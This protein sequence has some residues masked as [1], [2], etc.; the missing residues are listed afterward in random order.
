MRAD[1]S[2][3][4]VL[5]V[6]DSKTQSMMLVLAFEDLGYVC[7]TA[8]TLKEAHQKL[9]EKSYDLVTLDINLPDGKGTDLLDKFDVFTDNKTQVAI[10]SG[11]AYSLPMEYLRSYNILDYF[12]KDGTLAKTV[13]DIDK[14]YRNR[15]NNSE[16]KIVVVDDSEEVRSTLH[17]L[18]K[19][20]NYQVFEA[21][22][23]EE[24]L[25][26]LEEQ[27][28][29]MLLLDLT[30]S[31][32]PGSQ[33]LEKVK[34]KRE[35]L[36][37]PVLILSEK[38]PS[39]VISKMYKLG[40]SDFVRK[41]FVYEELLIKVDFWVD[42]YR[43]HV[44]LLSEQKFLKEY[45]NAVDASNIVSKADKYG[46]ITFVNDAFC[47]VSGYT[48]EELVGQ[49]HKIVRHPD[50]KAEVFKD[51]WQTIAA[52]KL[53]RGIIKNRT[54][55]GRHY[56]VDTT[57]SPIT[58][59]EGNIVE[60]IAVRKDITELEEIRQT[61]KEELQATTADFKEVLEEKQALMVQ[62]A[63]FR[64]MEEMIGNIAHQWRQPLAALGLVIQK[65]KL[66]YQRGKLDE[67]KIDSIIEKSM[68]L[69]NEMSGTIDDFRN[70]F[71]PNKEKEYFDVGEMIA[72]AYAVVRRSFAEYQIEYRSN[73]DTAIE[74]K[75]H[76]NE[77]QQVIVSLFKNAKD[78]LIEHR[79]E[80]PY[81]EV[82]VEKSE[83]KVLITVCDNGGGIPEAELRKIFEPYFTTKEEGKGKGVGL[84][85]SKI[86]IEE[87][88]NGSLQ[89]KNSEEGACFTIEI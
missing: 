52:K 18:L 2:Q 35:Y 45:Q 12:V 70:S 84:Y 9:S 42:Y 71:N 26:L 15:I 89:V 79:V 85:M 32:M 61:L 31:D 56:Y 24:G 83:D 1:K 55:D 57:I 8:E 49:P 46:I 25:K 19:S 75:G 76:E 20:R 34:S 11:E 58:D 3:L 60:Y 88:M 21:S 87:H 16:S 50:M 51:L 33:F 53:W 82:K 36:D 54:T 64:S 7:D 14:L 67:E 41:P 68:Y 47:Q 6:E 43:N 37:L 44:K 59:H 62:H 73:I 77:L 22:S 4:N 48:P 5:I 65:I 29:Q 80:N 30:L 10:Y 27:R 39:A 74:I 28:P 78:I 69:I 38:E 81:I 86:I 40:A 66:F 72:K 23:A 63:R 13:S 17:I